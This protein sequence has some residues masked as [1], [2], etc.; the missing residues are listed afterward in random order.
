MSNVIFDPERWESAEAGDDALIERWLV[1][2]GDYVHAGQALAQAT[3][4]HENVAV[5]APHAG[6]LEQIVV[7]AGEHFGRGAVLARLIDV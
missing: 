3:L 4:V 1:T 5:E 7:A 6:V 2:E